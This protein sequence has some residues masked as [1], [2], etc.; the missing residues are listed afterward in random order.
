MFLIRI[1]APL[2]GCIF[3][4]S[5]PSSD[6]FIVIRIEKVLQGDLSECVEPYL[7]EDKN[8]DKLKSVAVSVCERLGKYR[9]AFAWTAI[10]LVNVIN[11]GNSLERDS[12]RDSMSS[13]SNTNSLGEFFA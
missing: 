11:G 8:R 9:Q 6:I 4:I 3:N 13:G 2:R 5:Q 7:K 1:L 12:D 10:N